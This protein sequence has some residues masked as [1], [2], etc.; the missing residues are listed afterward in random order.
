MFLLIVVML[1]MLILLGFLPP[2]QEL[3]HCLK[4]GVI[5][6]SVAKLDADDGVSLSVP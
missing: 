2:S 1:T 3:R 4:F 5:C 6:I